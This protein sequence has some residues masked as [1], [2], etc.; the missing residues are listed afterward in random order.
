MATL[1]EIRRR[2]AGIKSTEKITKAM[3]MVAAAKLRRFQEAI[4]ATRP[5]AKRMQGV[6]TRLL[7]ETSTL[8]HPFI[9]QRPLRRAALVVLASDRGLC[10]AFNST[11][12]RAAVDYYQRHSN[13]AELL[14]IPIGKKAVD[15]FTKQGYTILSSYT[16]IVDSLQFHHAQRIVDELVSYYTKETIDRVDILYNE[17]KSVIQ[18]QVVVE[19]FL[20]FST[21][22]L[23]QQAYAR[24]TPPT[25]YIYEPSQIGILTALIPR[26][27]NYQMWRILLESATA[28]QAAR[29]TAMNNATENATELLEEL[30]LTYNKAR[31]AGITKELLEIVSGAEALKKAG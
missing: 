11:I 16:H 9:E 26:Y 2:I 29:M 10:G 31:Q 13:D 17:F 24:K 6:L 14:I 1:R 28:E 23:S 22:I 3:K 21:T 19:Q 8:T 25:H 7:N 5:Y 12:I 30:T 18:Q 15:F 20:P 27:L 4:F